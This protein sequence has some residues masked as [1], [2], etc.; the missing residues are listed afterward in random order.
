M[1]EHVVFGLFR[2]ARGHR[3]SMKAAK[4]EEITPVTKPGLVRNW[5]QSRLTDALC[6]RAICAPRCSSV[7]RRITTGF[8]QDISANTGIG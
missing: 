6:S 3:V 8:I 7:A 5:P 1:I 2:H 4:P